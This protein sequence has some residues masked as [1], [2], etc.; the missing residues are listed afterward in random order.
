MD[1]KYSLGSL[2][3]CTASATGTY[4]ARLRVPIGALVKRAQPPDLTRRKNI[5][6]ESSCIESSWYTTKKKRE[7]PKKRRYNNPALNNTVSIIHWPGTFYSLHCRAPH[8]F[9]FDP[10][11]TASLAGL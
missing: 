3:G 11:H 6:N 5:A 8:L 1:C 10:A 9:F 2:P 4:Q 7:T